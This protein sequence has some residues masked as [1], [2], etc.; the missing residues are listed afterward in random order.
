[1]PNDTSVA[2]R[3]DLPSWFSDQACHNPGCTITEDERN[4]RL[5]RNWIS[6]S[7]KRKQSLY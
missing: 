6:L 7:M 5:K 1:M 3:E 4:F 2:S